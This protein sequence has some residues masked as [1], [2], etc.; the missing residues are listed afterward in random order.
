MDFHRLVDRVD[1]GKGLIWWNFPHKI[2]ENS[3]FS[4]Q[5][6]VE[7]FSEK[8]CFKHFF[9]KIVRRAE[10]NRAEEDPVH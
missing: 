10:V 8:I 7:Q 4:V 2:N 1:K 6:D 9:K 5:V 3:K